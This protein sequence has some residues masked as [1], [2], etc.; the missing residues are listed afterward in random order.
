M[1]NTADRL[2]KFRPTQDNVLVALLPEAERQGSIVLPGTRKGDARRTRFARVVSSGPGYRLRNGHGPLVKN[3][4]LPGDVVIIDRVAG[5]DYGF[6]LNKPRQNR[7]T[8]SDG[9]RVVRHDEIHGVVKDYVA[10]SAGG[11]L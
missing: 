7:H 10:E 8:E 2:A 3:D 1:G 5:Q 6:D 9:M 4:V 11:D